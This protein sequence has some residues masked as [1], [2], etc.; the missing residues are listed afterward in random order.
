[1]PATVFLRLALLLIALV[2]CD[3]VHA[4]IRRCMASNGTTIYT[5][6]R[7]QDLGAVERLA[8]DRQAGSARSYRYSCAR[9]PQDLIYQLSDAINNRDV[10]QMASV[11]YWAGQSTRTGYALMRRLDAIARRPLADIVPIYPAVREEVDGAVDATGSDG[12]E[13]PQQPASRRLVG[14]RL[15]QTLGNGSTPARTFL[16]LRHAH[17]C[18]WIIL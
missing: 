10:N 18:W 14:L 7:C 17:G 3:G 8:D 11:Y 12:G 2:G 1:M 15:E 4:Q 9:S 6:R 5:D 16:G 13:Y